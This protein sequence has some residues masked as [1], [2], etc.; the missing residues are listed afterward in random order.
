MHRLN[1]D[2]G[3]TLV[4]TAIVIALMFAFAAFAVDIAS[5]Y[6]ER[7]QL[8]N[9][10]DAAVLAIAEDCAWG[11]P[12]D[13]ATAEATAQIYADANAADLS[14]TVEAV[15]LDLIEQTVT[16]HTLSHD[17][18]TGLNAVSHF[19]AVVMGIDSSPVRAQA[20]A[21]WGVLGAWASVP[22]VMSM[23]DVDESSATEAPGEIITFHNASDE[24]KGCDPA[25]GFSSLTDDD[26]T[27]WLPAGFGTLKAEP[28]D[29]CKTLTV[30]TDE[31]SDDPAHW[32]FG[33]P[34][35][36]NASSLKDCLWKVREEGQAL[37]HVPI[38][39]GFL[40]NTDPYCKDI[41]PLNSSESPCYQIG[42]YAPFM[43]TGYWFPGYKHDLEK[44][45]CKSDD[46]TELSAA[47]V[48]GWFTGNVIPVGEIGPAFDFGTIVV[49]LIK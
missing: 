36:P 31:P 27:E 29:H 4:F 9:G 33:Q 23:C 35:D 32:A 18:N 12:C 24:T 44:N 11:L 41:N 1:R 8:Q 22:L 6:Q 3:A 17:P 43:M 39:V 42:G 49:Q 19:F 5:L 46:D 25:P 30:A 34:Q 2:S 40:Q 48:R 10:A 14:T 21:Q 13:Q 38:F 15:E 45:D 26:G 7:R 16:V 28:D 47:C 37:Y 20:T